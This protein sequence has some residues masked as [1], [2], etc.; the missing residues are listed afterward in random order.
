MSDGEKP[1]PLTAIE[2]PTVAV[3][4]VIVMCAVDCVTVN[5]ALASSLSAPVVSTVTTY[6][7]CDVASGTAKVPDNK[8][9]EIEHVVDQDTV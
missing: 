5:I 2:V 7:P 6:V 4:G 3:I 8:P 1:D 9:P